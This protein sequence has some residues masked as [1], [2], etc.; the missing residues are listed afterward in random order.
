MNVYTSGMTYDCTQ[1]SHIDLLPLSIILL[2][3]GTLGLFTAS[4]R[5]IAVLCVF[6]L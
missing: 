1:S 3:E 4:G 5:P 6:S 2:S